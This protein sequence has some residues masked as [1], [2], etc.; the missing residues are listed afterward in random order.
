[1]NRVRSEFLVLHVNIS[2]TIDLLNCEGSKQ[3]SGKI[4]ENQKTKNLSIVKL[5]AITRVYN[6]GINFFSRGQSK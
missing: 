2:T 3:K 4:L 1:M 6:L 5:R